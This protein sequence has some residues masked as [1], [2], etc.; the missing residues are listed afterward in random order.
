MRRYVMIIAICTG[1][2]WGGP[3]A[4]EDADMAVFD[5]AWADFKRG[6]FAQAWDGFRAEAENFLGDMYDKGLV[7]SE[8]PARAVEWYRRSAA[9]GVT[10]AQ[11]NLGRMY[12]EGRGVSQDHGEAMK[13]YLVAAER[14]V[15]KARFNLGI[16]YQNGWGVPADDARALKWYREAARQGYAD[17]QVNLG[18][19]YAVGQG[20][21]KDLVQAHMWS[22][23]A[24][25]RGNEMAMDNRALVAEKMTAAEIA[26]AQ[27][28][29]REWKPGK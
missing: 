2:L 29:A 7:V 26:E 21:P 17:A 20:V 8:D 9:G 3:A 19:R 16:I 23:L 14:G 18:F 4:A 11:V 12:A 25:E 13:W 27:R 1:G 22:N 6:D 5:R 15:A 10:D 28:L 24:A